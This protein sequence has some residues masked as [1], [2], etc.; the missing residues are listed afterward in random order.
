MKNLLLKK[1]WA[2]RTMDRAESARRL[3]PVLR[4][5]H[6]LNY[7]YD[8]AI[9][10]LD[11]GE[12][13]DRLAAF[14]RTARA[15]AGKL[16]ESVLSLGGIPQTGVDMEPDAYDPG[17][18]RDSILRRLIEIEERFVEQIDAENKVEHQMRSRAILG[19]T[20]QNTRERLDFLKSALDE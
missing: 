13:T 5:H 17:S 20:R 16:S 18:D 2:G 19:N 7:T 12:L 4:A 11:N 1:G 14:Q 6:E 8:A 3:N 10:R 9:A 15:D